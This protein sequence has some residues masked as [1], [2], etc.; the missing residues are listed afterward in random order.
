MTLPD[1]EWVGKQKILVILAHPDDPEF[2]CG[3][4]I[5]RWVKRGHEVVYYLLTKGDKGSN[6]RSITPDELSR[7]REI[8][9]KEA[10]GVLG[11]KKVYFLDYKDGYVIPDLGLRR[12]VTRIIRKETPNIL[13]SCDPT[14]IFPRMGAIN[15]PDHR[16]V[17]QIVVDSIF[18]ASGNHLY[19]PELL[20]EGWQPHIVKELWLSVAAN[21]NITIDVTEEWQ[22]KIEALKKHSSQIGDPQV[23]AERMQKRRSPE[24][25]EENPRYEEKFY[26]IAF[27]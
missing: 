26:R 3:G 12:D 15:H 25:C 5:S 11:V 20:E 14:N 24:S 19:F 6:D 16:A 22:S 9:Q 21:P 1:D 13:V 2:F 7:R 27:G 10:A 23:F 18:P 4:S 8:E 17:G